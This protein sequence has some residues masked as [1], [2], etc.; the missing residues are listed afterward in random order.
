MSEPDTTRLLV[1]KIEIAKMLDISTRHVDKLRA[2]GLPTVTLG[3]AVRFRPSSVDAWLA[4]QETRE[5]TPEAP[6]T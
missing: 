6:I 4:A 2:D 3:K 1:D 5:T